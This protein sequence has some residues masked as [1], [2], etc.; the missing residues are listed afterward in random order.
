[1]AE[2]SPYEEEQEIEDSIEEELLALLLVALVVSAKEFDGVFSYTL[3]TQ[4]NNILSTRLSSIVPSL[5]Q[6]ASQA[7]RAGLSRAPSPLNKLEYDFSKTSFTATLSDILS[8]KLSGYA[9]TNIRMADRVLE[10]AGQRGWDDE[11]INRRL[12][13][14][15]GLTPSH[16]DTLITLE[17]NMRANGSS[18][19]A[20]NRT[21]QKKIDNLIEWRGRLTAAQV[22]TSVVEQSKAVA[23]EEMFEDGD[24]PSD[25]VKQAVA[26]LDNVTTQICTSSHLT[27]AELNGNF[28][29]GFFSPP[30]DNPV[31]PC[32]T[33][34]RIIKRPT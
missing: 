6:G 19:A 4:A 11:E 15:W 5:T 21:V 33:S 29:N 22:A 34:I 8:D 9:S 13:M 1:M 30:F 20:I 18:K 32:R 7:I 17:D 10:Y 14:Y 26:V 2:Q 25:Y 24:I 27:V 16:V 3:V 23:F 12:K 31:H 28:P